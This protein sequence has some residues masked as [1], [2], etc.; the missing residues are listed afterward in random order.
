MRTSFKSKKDVSLSE[1][2]ALFN[3]S[4]LGY[5]SGICSVNVVLSMVNISSRYLETKGRDLT[6]SYDKSPYT[7]RNVKRAKWQHK[8][9]H[10]K[11]DYTA[12]A[13]RLRTV[14]SS[15]YSHPAGVV[16]R[17]YRAN[18]PTH[19]NSCVIEGKNTQILL[20]IDMKVAQ[21]YIIRK[22]FSVAFLHY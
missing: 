2:Y 20:Y 18:L 19:C 9:R 10:K 6:Q 22:I 4:S 8:Q 5:I 16:Y 1:V 13:D 21:K 15:I 12:I 14:S 17:F 3:R 11:F 7:N